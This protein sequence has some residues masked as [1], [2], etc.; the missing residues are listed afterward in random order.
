MVEE[1]GNFRPER[2]KKKERTSRAESRGSRAS[3]SAY[4]E[5]N[6][7]SGRGSE[8]GSRTANNRTS[9][10]RRSF[11]DLGT[12]SRNRTGFDYSRRRSGMPP[13]SRSG[14]NL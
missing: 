7:R 2:K 5:E 4:E 1:L 6:S 13:A 9:Q 8:Y 12:S 3:G 10:Q 14:Y 11:H